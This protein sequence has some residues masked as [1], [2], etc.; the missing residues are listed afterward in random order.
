MSVGLQKAKAA[1]ETLTAIHFVAAIDAIHD[2]ITFLMR[3]NAVGLVE[4][5][6]PATEHA[7]VAVGRRAGLELVLALLAVL[8]VI[9]H[10]QRRYTFA[11][12]TFE[13]PA[14]AWHGGAVA[15][16]ICERERRK[17]I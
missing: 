10:P 13:H 2:H 17:K 9:A 6:L 5:V 11:L 1:R 14:G 15:I 12:G 4:D 16:R 3:R 7:V 8:L